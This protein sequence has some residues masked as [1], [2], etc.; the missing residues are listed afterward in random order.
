M[1]LLIPPPLSI[2]LNLQIVDGML[3]VINEP[4]R[5]TWLRVA[6]ALLVIILIIFGIR[7]IKNLDRNTPNQSQK[8]N[9]FQ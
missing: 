4:M 7:M 1:L 8:G 6:L 9:P 3:I 5:K 2:S